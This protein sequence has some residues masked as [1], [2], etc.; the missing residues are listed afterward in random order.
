MY[1]NLF[2]SIGLIRATDLRKSS[3]QSIMKLK[4]LISDITI[5]R[6]E[7]NADIEIADITTDSRTVK[8]VIN[9]TKFLRQLD[10][11]IVLV[12]SCLI[13]LDNVCGS[14]NRYIDRLAFN[15]S[16]VLKLSS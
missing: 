4:E 13:F 9:Y 11:G 12:L 2:D 10:A 6:M 7:G 15:A 3:Y 1:N 14:R 8:Q 16:K 5:I